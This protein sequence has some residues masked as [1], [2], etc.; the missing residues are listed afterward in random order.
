MN[1]T[2]PLCRERITRRIGAGSGLGTSEWIIARPAEEANA[3]MKARGLY[4][5]S[6]GAMKKPFAVVTLLMVTVAPTS[7]T[8][9]VRVE[10]PNFVVFGEVGEKRTK[11]VAVEFLPRK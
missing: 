3:A 8:E 10:T 11:E 6:R 2:K 4:S 7:A 9:W 1:I 5:R